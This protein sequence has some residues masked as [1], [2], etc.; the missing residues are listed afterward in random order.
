VPDTPE[1][2]DLPDLP[3]NVDK[4]CHVVVKARQFDVKE[5][6]VESDYGGNQIDD[7]FRPVLADSPDDPTYAELRAFIRALSS[8]ERCALIALMW[9]G[10]GDYGPSEWNDAMELARREHELQADEYLLG[11][12]LLPDLLEEGLA[13]FDENCTDFERN[14]L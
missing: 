14:H 3:I 13:A 11:T 12:A 1:D 8:D 2:S 10:R 5:G 7:E 4:V 6:V 9:I